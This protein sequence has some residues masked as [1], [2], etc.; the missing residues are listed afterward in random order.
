MK[1]K[2]QKKTNTEVLAEVANKISTELEI[3]ERLAEMVSKLEMSL[4]IEENINQIISKYESGKI[5]QYAGTVN[6]DGYLELKGCSKYGFNDPLV[7]LFKVSKIINIFL[8]VKELG[9]R[10][11]LKLGNRI[12]VDVKNK[13]VSI[14]KTIGSLFIL[15][16]IISNAVSM[17]ESDFDIWDDIICVFSRPVSKFDKFVETDKGFFLINGE[18]HEYI[19]VGSKISILSP[20][21]IEILGVNKRVRCIGFQY[22]MFEPKNYNELKGLL[23]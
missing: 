15:D 6:D 16:L 18:E 23:C 12:S 3:G 10:V 2:I 9:N 4:V 20:K 7:A 22:I 14:A 13:S 21:F 1:K 8:E 11:I 5:L 17:I 19:E